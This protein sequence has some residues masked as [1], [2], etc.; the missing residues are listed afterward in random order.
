MWAHSML[1]L[2]LVAIRA[3]LRCRRG[4]LVVGAALASAGLGVA[5]F[6]IR[7][8]VLSS[9]TIDKF[10]SVLRD[11]LQAFPARVVDGL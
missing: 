5:A 10:G 2:L 1:Q 4:S 8:V 11:L 3:F 6:G 9:Y 7:H